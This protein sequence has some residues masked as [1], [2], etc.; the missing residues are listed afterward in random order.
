VAR[1][2]NAL[3]HIRTTVGFS[4]SLAEFK[5]FLR[6]DRRFYAKTP[7][8]IGERMMAAIHLIEPKMS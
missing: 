7:E 5:T 2:N 4:G 6:T 8:E 3:D 1:I